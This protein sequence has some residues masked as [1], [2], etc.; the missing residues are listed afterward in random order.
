M[1]TESEKFQRK[2]VEEITDP[3]N[4]ISEMVPFQFSGKNRS[5]TEIKEA[6]YCY[7]KDLPRFVKL[8]LDANKE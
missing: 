3:E 2:Q 8:H 7:V 5:D 4:L 1:E 6:A